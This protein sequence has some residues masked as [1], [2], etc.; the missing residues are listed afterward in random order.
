[1]S[2]IDPHALPSSHR[3]QR[4]FNNVNQQIHTFCQQQTLA[5]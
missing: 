3:L 1:M 5:A 4:A 2:L